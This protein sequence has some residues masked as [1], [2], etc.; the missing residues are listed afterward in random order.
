MRN[1]LLLSAWALLTVPLQAQDRTVTP[2]AG[3]TFAATASALLGGEASVRVAPRLEVVG[4]LSYLR[5]IATDDARREMEQVAEA[6]EAF[7]RV[8]LGEQ[9]DIEVD[10]QGRGFHGAAGLRL[11]VPTARAFDLFLQG[12]VGFTRIAPT[13]RFL[14]GGSDVSNTIAPPLGLTETSPS[15]GFG[16]GARVPVSERLLVLARYHFIRVFAEEAFAPL[17]E[18]GYNVNRIAFGIGYRF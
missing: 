8:V 16:G 3:A 6:F 5:N 10:L 1:L 15:L 13:M 14:S 7:S 11:L 18:G 4:E 2:F 12:D 9:I 17:I